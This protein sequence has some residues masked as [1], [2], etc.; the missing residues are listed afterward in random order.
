M[1][2]LQVYNPQPHA[3]DQCNRSELDSHADTY[4]A[5]SNTT[6]L[7]YSDQCVSVSPF[8]GEYSPIKDVP[9]A[10]AS[11]ATAWDNPVDGSTLI[12]MINAALYS[13]D[14]MEYSLL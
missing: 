14:R 9:I 6:P 11:V 2:L 4:V 10:S 3:E 1:D 12:L 13:G 5:G 7:W 8:I